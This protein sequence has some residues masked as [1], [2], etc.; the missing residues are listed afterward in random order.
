MIIV[1]MGVSGSGKTMIGQ[2]VATLL[3]WDFSDADEYH[4]PA[5]VKKMNSGIP[6]TDEDR[7][8]WL[9]AL[10]AAIEQWKRGEP[11]HVLACSA[12]K[13]SY[14]EILG[15]DDPDVKF[16]YLRGAFDLIARRLKERKGHFFDPALLRSQFD[17][18][19]CPEDALVLDVSN[20]PEEIIS[21][22]LATIKLGG[23]KEEGRSKK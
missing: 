16:V 1:I 6:L 23:N 17:A 20:T 14:R 19:E 2:G 4:S 3:D 10:R 8:P 21:S 15:Q 18:L 7:E 12:L 9:R 5:N 11:G 22:I 13:A